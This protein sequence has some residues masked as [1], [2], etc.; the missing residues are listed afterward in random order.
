VNYQSLFFW[1]KIEKTIRSNFC[2]SFP[3]L[4]L[5]KLLQFFKFFLPY[6]MQC[7]AC[8]FVI[9]IIFYYQVYL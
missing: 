6:F 8:T 2:C 4:G 5:A 7:L 3:L 1:K 9:L